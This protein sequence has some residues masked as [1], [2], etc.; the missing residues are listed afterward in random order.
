MLGYLP[1]YLRGLGWPEASADGALATFHTVSMLCT[2]PIALGSDRLGSRRR[3]LLATA[4]MTALGSGLLSV[5]NGLWVW[6]AM[7]LAGLVRDGF[8]AI[9]LTMIVESDGVGPAYAGTATGFV[10]IFLGLG[11]VF[12]PPLGNS[13]AGVAPSA[14]FVFWMALTL[15]GVVGIVLTREPA[16]SPRAAST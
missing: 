14:P 6:L 16:L 3:V 4:L 12:A 11:N 1:L 7:I 8:M 5:A 15:L 10:M 13:L 9:F 2:L